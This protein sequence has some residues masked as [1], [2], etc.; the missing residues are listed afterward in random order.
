V[1]QVGYDRVKPVFEA[2]I[3][4]ERDN[5]YSFPDNMCVMLIISNP[6]TGMFVTDLSSLFYNQ[7][8]SL[9]SSLK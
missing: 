2:V 5:N 4:P 7:L 9:A 8:Y 6:E 3:T 1:L